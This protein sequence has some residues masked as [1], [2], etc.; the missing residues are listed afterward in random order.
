MTEQELKEVFDLLERSDIP[1]AQHR[2]I[3]KIKMVSQG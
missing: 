1:T 3:S 2:N